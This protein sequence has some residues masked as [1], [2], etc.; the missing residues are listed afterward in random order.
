M[1]LTHFH[2]DT[3]EIVRRVLEAARTRGTRIRVHYGSMKTGRDWMDEYDV[4]GKV[5]RSMGPQKVPIF[6]HNSRS[7][8]GP[9]ILTS[10]IVRVRYANKKEGGDLYRHPKYH[11]DDSKSA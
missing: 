5:G 10:C 6:I 4:A 8:G 1:D 7:M 9:A 11:V 2:P 3:P